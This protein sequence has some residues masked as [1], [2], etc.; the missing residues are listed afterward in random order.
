M[1]LSNIFGA[2]DVNGQLEKLARDL[3]KKIGKHRR[4]HPDS[5]PLYFE[6]KGMTL[7]EKDR[8]LSG[9]KR[10]DEFCR[11]KNIR[12]TVSRWYWPDKALFPVREKGLYILPQ[13]N[14]QA[15]CGIVIMLDK[16]YEQTA[17]EKKYAAE[18]WQK[19]G[20]VKDPPAPRQGK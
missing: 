15:P 4:K 14:P 3:E 13:Y 1:S 19:L 7:N 11:K 9:Y 8:M 6:I 12:L 2:S 18:V 10:I 17:A 16:P 20:V 5:E